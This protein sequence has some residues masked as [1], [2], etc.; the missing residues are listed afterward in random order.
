MQGEE[1]YLERTSDLVARVRK[2]REEAEKQMNRFT[3]PDDYDV[4]RVVGQ[5][6]KGNDEAVRSR[7][8]AKPTQLVI[9]LS[10]APSDHEI[11]GGKE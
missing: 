6:P 8:H 2:L 7:T 3:N 11:S 4:R 5:K 1:Q 9:D 10:P